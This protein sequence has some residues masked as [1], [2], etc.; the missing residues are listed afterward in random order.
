MR[1]NR[2]WVQFAAMLHGGM[3][4]RMDAVRILMEKFEIDEA[5]AGRLFKAGR[6]ANRAWARRSEDRHY[7][8]SV[9]FYRSVLMSGTAEAR[10][11]LK[12][13]ER[14]DKL[15]NVRRLNADGQSTLDVEDII[16]AVVR[17]AE[18]ATRIESGRDEVDKEPGDADG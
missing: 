12:A 11:K 6:Q 1:L 7:D 14:L 15:Q 17:I 10:Y 9:A 18:R 8:E 16:E 2:D 13:R 5:T 3:V 4:L